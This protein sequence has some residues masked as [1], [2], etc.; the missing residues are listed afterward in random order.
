MLKKYLSLFALLISGNLAWTAAPPPV[1]SLAYSPDGNLLAVGLY[2]E[3]LLLDSKS[4]DIR[5]KLGEQTRRVTALA[6]T[7]DGKR[8]A[9]A[10]GLAGK[11]GEIRVY[12]MSEN[13]PKVSPVIT[14]HSDIIYALDFSTDGTRLASTGYDRLIKIWDAKTLAESAT[15]KDHSDTVY[16]LQFQPNGTLLASAGAD[17]AVKLWDTKT[18]KRL[19]TLSDATD[20]VNCLAWAPD[21]KHLAAAG[22]DKSIR[23]W[24]IDPEGGKLVH[25]VFAHNQPILKLQY[26]QDGTSLY[27]IAEGK[28]PKRWDTAQ[29]KE[30]LVFQDLP[31]NPLSLAVHPTGKTLAVGLYGGTLLTLDG[32]TGKPLAT[33]L[34][35]KPKP[36]QISKITPHFVPRGVAS[37]I[38]IEGQSLE[39][40]IAVT[41]PH[42]ETKIL[43]KGAKLE[44]Q[45][46]PSPKAPLGFTSVT[47]K[48]EAGD[49]NPMNLIVDRFA[50]QNDQT[51]IESV[52]RGLLVT[53]PVTIAGIL[54]R[55][56]EADF[57][58]VKLPTQGEIGIQ[59]IGSAIGSKIDPIL[60]LI[61]PDG[62]TIAFS[63]K[64]F[65][66]VTVPK[67]GIYSISVHDKDYRGGGE[68]FYRLHVGNIP[69]VSAVFPAG[70][71]QGKNAEI[72]LIGSYLPTQK[73]VV[74]AP[75]DAPVGS[76]IP[77]PVP[78]EV[79]GSP[80]LIV[81][82][83]PEVLVQDRRATL[84]GLGTANGILDKDQ[85]SDL[86]TFSAKKGE[87]LVVE[88][89]AR[90]LGAPLDTC[91]EI[92]DTKGQ[93]VGKATLRCV[94]RT[95]TTFRDHDSVNPGIRLE[96]WN[97]LAIND[98]VYI[99]NQLLKIK[100]LPLNPDADCNFEA[101]SG[102][103]LGYLGTTP[104]HVANNTPLYKVTIHPFGTPFPPNGMPVFHLYERNDD[105]GP[106]YGKDSRIDFVAPADGEYQVK[107]SDARS[108]GSA[109]SVYR[110]TIRKPKPDF[111]ISFSPTSPNVWGGGSIPINVTAKRIDQFSGPIQIKLENLP[112]G[113]EAPPT[114]IEAEQFT[115][116]FAL[117][118]KPG[119]ASP[120]KNQPIK[121][122]ATA[123][124]DGQKVTKEVLGETPKVISG[125]DIV[126]TT[127]SDQVTIV[128]GQEARIKVKIERHNKFTGRVPL[129]VRGLP[130]GVR[131]LD[132]GLNG[133]LINPNETEREITLYCEPWVNPMEHPFIVLAKRE[134]KNTEHGARSM[135][136]RVQKK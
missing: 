48:N 80:T 10:S 113:F 38:Q 29:F 126:T 20:G 46:T 123:L 31:D 82:D 91:I 69:I 34:P 60:E 78:E 22:A 96:T 37:T 71:Q 83:L 47:V 122:V 76:K 116:T 3:V 35:M 133:I 89:N 129:E 77:V 50:A 27:S 70:I 30:K 136:L 130:H 103:R 56:G 93:P 95:F 61:D 127:L 12:E 1:G 41:I 32:E 87:H 125:G 73:I 4:G 42:A 94:A 17:R 45:V 106:G 84:K 100:A 101:E 107:V 21:G 33:L 66:G 23:V 13:P 59:L 135:L 57:Y 134:G 44:I 43:K 120:V 39:K 104:T 111:T 108:Q 97:E 19:Y 128:P 63:D 98:Y 90:R 75:P 11:S 121:L 9:V 115:T 72:Q 114:F 62:K 64:G 74:Q 112:E 79:L 65:L 81:G 117:Y 55:A 40:T 7:R 132:I 68:F 8:L 86:I 6:W 119:I 26:S 58:R 15:L 2:G 118:A 54:Q 131:V 53:P 5:H 16:G 18:G 28:T 105:G 92:L 85:V 36:P 102:Q 24:K 110:L 52:Q 49:S 67:E 25:S 14:G 99:G 88:T 124:I 109:N 51:G